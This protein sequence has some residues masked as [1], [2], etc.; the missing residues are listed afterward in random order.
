MRACV[1]KKNKVIRIM[2]IE[3]QTANQSNT[4]RKHKRR[5]RHNLKS[6]NRHSLSISP[7]PSCS[8]PMC[9]YPCSR[10]VC[11]YEQG[12][13]CITYATASCCAKSTRRVSNQLEESRGGNLP[14]TH[15][16]YNYKGP[17]GGRCGANLALARELLRTRL[18]SVCG[19]QATEIQ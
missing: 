11:V 9:V 4:D 7:L 6:I 8:L 17:H 18:R 13:T 15:A 16:L 2:R 19:I 3:I 14:S 12:T 10:R 5:E 1:R